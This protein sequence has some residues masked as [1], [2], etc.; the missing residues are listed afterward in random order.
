MADNGHKHKIKPNEYTL[1]IH[2]DYVSKICKDMNLWQHT[3]EL[4][5]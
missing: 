2:S 4:S 5:T 3:S 1:S